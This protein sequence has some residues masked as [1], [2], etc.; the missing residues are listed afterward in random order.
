MP[1]VVLG[2]ASGVTIV[3]G[4]QRRVT[5]KLGSELLTLPITS[6]EVEHSEIGPEWVLIPRFRQEP[7][8]RK[9]TARLRQMK[10][11]VMFTAGGRPVEGG[12]RLLERFANAESPLNVS[13]GPLET[14]L[15]RLH[16]HRIRSRKRQP[17]TDA[18]VQAEVELTFVRFASGGY[19]GGAKTPTVATPAKPK[20]TPAKV[21]PKAVPRTYV[22]RSG[23]TLSKIAARFYGDADRF[24]DIAA[25]NKIANPNR[26][27]VGQKLIIP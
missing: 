5:I 22:V 17:E 20:A 3:A 24:R 26:I 4:P 6:P 2:I 10:M 14:G 13:Y 19:T 21:P 8:Q 1:S 16:D 23:D 9:N 11:T 25:A 27:S 15:F 12:L 7:L 18:I